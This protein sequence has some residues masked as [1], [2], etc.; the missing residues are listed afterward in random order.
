MSAPLDP[1]SVTAPVDR[2]TVEA[3]AASVRASLRRFA[4][5]P[6]LA[7]LATAA[8][9]DQ[10]MGRGYRFPEVE[11]AALLCWREGEQDEKALP[12]G[13]DVDEL[14]K[15]LGRLFFTTEQ[16]YGAEAERARTRRDRAEIIHRLR[17]TGLGIRVRAYPVHETAVLRGLF[18]PFAK[19][20]R[21]SHG[22]DIEDVLQCFSAVIALLNE[23]TQRFRTEASGV[24]DQATCDAHF[25]CL[26]DYLLFDAETLGT[27]AG[28]D[29]S[30]AAAV[31]ATFGL[32]RGAVGDEVLLPSPF[33]ALRE[34]PLLAVG[35]DRFMAL[36]P[37]LLLASVQGR[38]ETLLNPALTASAARGTW[39]RYQEKRGA[40]VEEASRTLLDRMMPHGRGTIGAYYDVAPGQRVEADVVHQ[41]DD[42]VFLLEAKA[43]V[44]APPSFRGAGNSLDNDIE[45]IVTKGHDQA[46]RT[47]AYLLSGARGFRDEHDVPSFSISEPLREIV[48]IV[49][50]LDALGVLGTAAAAMQRA[51]YMS[52]HAT[53]VVSLFDLMA[54]ADGMGMPGEFR[55]Y[56][57]RRYEAMAD[58]RTLLFDELDLLGIYQTHN[59]MTFMH[60]DNA[61][62]VAPVGFTDAHDLYYEGGV[63]SPP[64]QDVPEVLEHIINALAAES[65]A[66]WSNAVCDL[67]ALDGRSRREFASDIEAGLERGFARPR[68][69]TYGVDGWGISI[70]TMPGATPKALRDTFLRTVVDP[71]LPLVQRRLLIAYD[72]SSGRATAGYFQ[73]IGN[74]HERIAPG[75]FWSSQISTQSH[76]G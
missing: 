49:V 11:Y 19:E 4:S 69:V 18:S 8:A 3:E 20:L 44:F 46:R 15:E 62:M 53:W 47:E 56:A 1:V 5:L 63:G 17:S 37:D 75:V 40:W 27:K 32:S 48:R 41:V 10:I 55:H 9:A 14:R 52:G 22:F 65:D 61:D 60:L 73:R 38:L 54:I 45:A 39:A 42:C 64:R 50:T 25:A 66:D 51:G 26:P 28:V 57:R 58:E 71:R 23:G 30:V 21:I 2:A 67:L 72:P 43:G 29:A 16:Y 33:S 35:D 59:D 12:T 74:E 76:T 36:N 6:L 68:S 34:R 70:V 13:A 31:L 24:T 7:N